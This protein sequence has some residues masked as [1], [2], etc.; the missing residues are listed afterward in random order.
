MFT[1]D[2][3]TRILEAGRRA[4][5]QAAHSRR[6]ARP[7]RR[8][9]GRRGRRR[10]LGRSPDLRRRRTASRAMAAARTSTATL[11]PAAA[12][13]LK[14]GRFAP[15]RA[16]I[17]RGG[18]GR[19]RDRRQPGGGFSPSMPFAMTLAC[20]AHGHD[21]RGGA[22]RAR[23]STPRGRSTAPTSSAASSRA[24]SPTPCSSRG[25]AINL[26][27]VGAPA[28]AARHQARAIV[29]GSTGVLTDMPDSPI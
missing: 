25:D 9:A 20:F 16:L 19:A 12:F 28:I 29:A 10:A 3:S 17:A 13:Y 14:L 2:E 8:I 6:R 5:L 7:E 21:V 15:A 24:S 11:L 27:R 26:I 22:R 4:G 18:A 23:R 1:P